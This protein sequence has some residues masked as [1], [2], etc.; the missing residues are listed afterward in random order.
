MTRKDTIIIAVFV[1]AALLI[2]L[3]ISAIKK[4][5]P[6]AV[7]KKVEKAQ[8]IASPSP[9]PKTEI[10]KAQGDEIDKVLKE[11]SQKNSV[12]KIEPNRP[13]QKIDFAK[14]LESITKSVEVKR[15][16][17]VSKSSSDYIEVTVK[18]G[19]ALEKIARAHQS[20]VHEIIECNHLKSTILNIGQ[21]LKIPNKKKENKAAVLNINYYT[22]KTG[23]N[24]WSIAVKN[25]MKVEEL[26]KLN[27]LNEEKARHLKPGDRL[28]IQ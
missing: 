22:V 7:S 4:E 8:P 6:I 27:N 26:L 25:H 10:K 24:P 28:R 14:E 19:D 13:A 17:P 11:F 1:N 9:P 3:F 20:S 15:P 21:V 5:E 2:A 12:A 23:D 16:E 18:K